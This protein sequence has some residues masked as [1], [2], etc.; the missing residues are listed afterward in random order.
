MECRR[1]VA[2]RA[3]E[4]EKQAGRRVGVPPTHFRI[5]N[6]AHLRPQVLALLIHRAIGGGQA[7]VPPA[8]GWN[9]ACKGE[10]QRALAG[11]QKSLLNKNE[12]KRWRRIRGLKRSSQGLKAVVAGIASS[13]GAPAGS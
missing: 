12:A 11:S 10:R 2:G 5:E 4:L 7:A 13:A 3:Q 8:A 9:A 1:D 6:P